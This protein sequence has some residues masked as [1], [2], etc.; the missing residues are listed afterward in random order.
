MARADNNIDIFLNELLAG[1]SQRQAFYI[2][3]PNSKKWKDV[4]VDNRA[5]ELL[6]KVR[7]R[8]GITNF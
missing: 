1:K 3:Y 8:R 4:T 5:S 6:K 2:A 7:L